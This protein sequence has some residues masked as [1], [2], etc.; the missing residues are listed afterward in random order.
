MNVA[1][2][3]YIFNRFNE[4]GPDFRVGLWLLIPKYSRSLSG[5]LDGHSM[6][7]ANIPIVNCIVANPDREADNVLRESRKKAFHK[8][9]IVSVVSSL[10]FIAISGPAGL[11]GQPT[12]QPKAIRKFCPI[13]ANLSMDIDADFPRA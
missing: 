9:L 12:Y 2:T 5:A 10:A 6:H 7:D 8:V 4:R 3:N 1:L 13:A 11:A